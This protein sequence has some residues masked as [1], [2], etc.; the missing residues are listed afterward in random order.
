MALAALHDA[1]N[2]EGQVW[3]AVAGACWQAAKDIENEDPGTSN[4]A[5]RLLWAAEV[6]QGRKSMALK[7]IEDVLKNAT[8]AADPYGASMTLAEYDNA[9][10][11]VVNSLINTYATGE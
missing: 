10:Q 1:L 2:G 11:F 8:L 7:M 5:N 6:R 4:H 9:V 3:K